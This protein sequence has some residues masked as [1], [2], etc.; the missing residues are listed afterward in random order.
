M[1]DF[2]VKLNYFVVVVVLVANKFFPC[3]PLASLAW[4]LGGMIFV[5]LLTLTSGCVEA[6]LGFGQ[7]C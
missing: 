7:Y 3:L 1:I 5:L 4:S 6:R 2:K